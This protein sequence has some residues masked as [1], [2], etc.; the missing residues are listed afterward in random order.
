MKTDKKIGLALGSG[1]GRG[2]AHIGVIKSLNKNGVPIDFIA[3]S[4]VG[5][6]IGGLYAATADIKEVEKIANSLNFKKFIKSFFKGV[7]SR[8]TI[9]DKN[10]DI[11]FEKIIGGI[12]IEDL[13]IPFCAVGSNLLTGEIELIRQGSLITAMK[14]SSAIPLLLKPV[15][16]DDK[17]IFDGGMISPVPVKVVKQMGADVAIGV[18]LYGNIFPI[19][20]KK[21]KRMSK[22]KAGM[23]SRF[24]A[25]NKLAEIDL[26]DADVSLSLKIPNEDYGVFKKFLSNQQLI[27]Y[28]FK[29]TEEKIKDIKSKLIE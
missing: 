10:F 22:L 17:Y 25:L 6:I 2:L 5:A 1:G 29:S 9:L 7:V 15:K 26:L 27:D 28:G 19:E 20:L 23:L 14:A 16:I 13:K 4:S 21:N 11:Y 18:S 12:N 24:L 8:K 3:G